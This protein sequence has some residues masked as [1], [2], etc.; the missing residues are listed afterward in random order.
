MW[1]ST[2]LGAIAV[3]DGIC[4]DAEGG[5]TWD[6]FFFFCEHITEITITNGGEDYLF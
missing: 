3:S 4:H 5:S 1:S 2:E 6:V